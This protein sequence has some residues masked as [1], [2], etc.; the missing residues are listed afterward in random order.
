[1]VQPDDLFASV[2]DVAAARMWF[3]TVELG[4]MLVLVK[5]V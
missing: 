1:M 4:R 5:I 2:S 3:Q